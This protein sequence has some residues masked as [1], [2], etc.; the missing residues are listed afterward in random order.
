MR[1]AAATDFGHYRKAPELLVSMIRADAAIPLRFVASLSSLIIDQVQ[2]IQRQLDAARAR[3][4]RGAKLTYL[5]CGVSLLRFPAH[6]VSSLRH[7]K[8]SK[9]NPIGSALYRH[10]RSRSSSSDGALQ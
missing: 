1:D 8:N 7:D 2:H 3:A 4:W 9:K 10:R 5:P 6:T